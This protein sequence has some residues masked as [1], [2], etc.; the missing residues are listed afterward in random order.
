MRLRCRHVA[1]CTAVL[2]AGCNDSVGPLLDAVEQR[3]QGVVSIAFESHSARLPVGAAQRLTLLATD[4]EGQQ[5]VFTGDVTWQS[6]EG[7]VISVNS[8]LLD[9]LAVGTSTVT[10][11]V[12]AAEA[13]TTLEAYASPLASFAFNPDPLSV[14]ECRTGNATATGSFADGSSFL[15][16]PPFLVSAPSNV[17]VTNGDDSLGVHAQASGSYAVQVSDSGVPATLNLVAADT[18]ASLALD[19]TSVSLAVGATRQF[20]ATATFSDSSTLDVSNLGTWTLVDET[21]TTALTL[22][23]TTNGLV[24]ADATGSG[25]VRFACGGLQA[26]ASVVVDPGAVLQRIEIGSGAGDIDLASG[27]TQALVLTAHFADGSSVIVT[28]Q[29]EWTVTLGDTSALSV[30]NTAG[31][32]G[33]VAAA[34]GITT[35]TSAIVEASYSGLSTLV[36]V[37]VA[38]TS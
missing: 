10:A 3:E 33:T 2:V 19:A 17:V 24:Q 35:Q 22:S 32:K 34:S 30:N 31:S 20:V 16:L 4:F 29:A 25:T 5:S 27:A 9:S 21:P 7:S 26:D 18:L 15:L 28:E 12:G 6:S 36:R 11:R 13:S 38:R 23:T 1:L 14:D 8:G 37:F